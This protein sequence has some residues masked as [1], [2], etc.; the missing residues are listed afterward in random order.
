MI[1]GPEGIQDKVKQQ[2]L[3]T[4]LAKDQTEID[5][6]LKYYGDV[7][8]WNLHTLVE[9]VQMTEPRTSHGEYLVASIIAN[10]YYKNAKEGWLR[11]KQDK[12]KRPKK[13]AGKQTNLIRATFSGN[14]VAE[15]AIHER[16]RHTHEIIDANNIMRLEN[17]R[18]VKPPA[19]WAPVI[20]RPNPA[21]YN[22]HQFDGLCKTT[23]FIDLTVDN[24]KEACAIPNGNNHACT[25]MLSGTRNDIEAFCQTVCNITG[26]DCYLT[27]NANS[28]LLQHHGIPVP[29]ILTRADGVLYDI[30]D[31]A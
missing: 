31:M 22:I 6:M 16:L 13:N 28:W 27:N 30:P 15:I 23:Q 24:T 1:P 12:K 2:Y 8:V 29:G 11:E 21:N 3:T 7:P 19:T 4:D 17:G 14:I 9:H 25:L 26:M 20:F 10:C 18:P 5:R